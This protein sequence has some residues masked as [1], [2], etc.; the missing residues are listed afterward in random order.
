MDNQYLIPANAK[1]S[2]LIFGL[3]NVRDLIIFG[4]G[5]VVSFIL[6]LVLPVAELVFAIIALAPVLVTGFLVFPIP[7]YHNTLTFLTSFYTFITT[8]QKF[9]WKGWC[10]RDGE[11]ESK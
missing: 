5:I 7:N 1:K 10:C 3:F 6:L 9:I 11:S 4:S 8:R 2:M